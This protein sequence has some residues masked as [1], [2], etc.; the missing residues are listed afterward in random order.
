VADQIIPPQRASPPL[1]SLIFR[2]F[3]V[4]PGI[5]P[6]AVITRYRPEQTGFTGV[7]HSAQRRQPGRL[8]TDNSFRN[9][10][11]ALRADSASILKGGSLG[12]PSPCWPGWSRNSRRCC[13]I[14]NLTE[15]A[16]G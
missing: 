2:A 5:P 13:A 16:Q 10:P 9:S 1:R 8:G 7:G 15:A 14:S 11:R 6:F 3:L 12:C 4:F